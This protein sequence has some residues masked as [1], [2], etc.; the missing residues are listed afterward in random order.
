M[1]DRHL[2]RR[3]IRH[4]VISAGRRVNIVSG[5]SCAVADHD[6]NLYCAGV[7]LPS[8]ITHPCL[9]IVV[10][11]TNIDG[12]TN[13]INSEDWVGLLGDEPIPVDILAEKTIIEI[14]VVPM[15]DLAIPQNRTDIQALALGLLPIEN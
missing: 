2:P 10:I 7:G 6:V 3:K 4:D 8:P 13:P 5:N 1:Q 12:K 11:A 14:L 15:N 9:V